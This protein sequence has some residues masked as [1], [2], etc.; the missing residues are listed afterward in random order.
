MK[1]LIHNFCDKNPLELTAGPHG[2]FGKLVTIIQTSGSMR[3][4]HDIT[5]EQAM[6]MAAALVALVDSLSEVT[7]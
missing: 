7:A 5:P 2:K 6:E 1:K 3:F 4:Q